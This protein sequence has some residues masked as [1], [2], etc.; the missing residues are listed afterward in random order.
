MGEKYNKFLAPGAF[1]KEHELLRRVQT[2]APLSPQQMKD[3]RDQQDK[4][5]VVTAEDRLVGKA[6]LGGVVDQAVNEVYRE[7]LSAAADIAPT[8][9]GFLPGGSALA[10][11]SEWGLAAAQL[12]VP[13]EE[14]VGSFTARISAMNR[15]ANPQQYEQQELM[16]RQK[17]Q[18]AFLAQQA[19][20]QRPP[21]QPVVSFPPSYYAP[22]PPAPPSYYYA[23]A[24][25]PSYYYPPYVNPGYYYY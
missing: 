4:N 7:G 20:K 5:R 6:F 1:D 21:P 24:P 16:R 25:P 13:Q 18:A 8:V 22:P 9:L 15:K 17:A 11:A 19:Q 23:P 10:E 14:D 2:N 12:A 3:I